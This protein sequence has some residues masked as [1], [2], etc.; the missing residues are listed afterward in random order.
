MTDS[1]D[2]RGRKPSISANH[3]GM[4]GW[5]TR[6][7]GGAGKG[8]SLTRKRLG[9]FMFHLLRMRG[10]VTSS[11]AMSDMEGS[12]VQVFF[13][14]PEGKRAE[15]EAASGITIEAPVYLVPA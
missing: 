3:P 6:D 5:V 2:A 1:V 8:L 10:T 11:Y 13:W 7:Y 9:E 15:L 4:E 14:L 12:Y